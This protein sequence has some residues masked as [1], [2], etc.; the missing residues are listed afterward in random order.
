MQI[1]KIRGLVIYTGLV[2]FMYAGGKV[3]LMSDTT[4]YGV[5]GVLLIGIPVYLVGMMEGRELG[6]SGY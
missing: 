2:V 5:I 6:R 3:L 4:A 1:R